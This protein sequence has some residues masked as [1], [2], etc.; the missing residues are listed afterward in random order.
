MNV[1]LDTR[2]LA[3][4]TEGFSG[5]DLAHLCE[6]ASENALMDSVGSGTVRMI[7]MTDFDRALAEVRP[8][9]RPWL[10]TA[11]N[12]ALYANA[13]GEYDELAAW[14]RKQRR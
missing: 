5:A 12:V 1:D 9:I 11:R 10:E 2:R 6:S 13:S 3:K 7:G 8:S 14:L 4:A